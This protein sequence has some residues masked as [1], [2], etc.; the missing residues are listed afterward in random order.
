MTPATLATLLAIL[1]HYTA[2]SS[3]SRLAEIADLLCEQEA[4][5]TLEIVTPNEPLLCWTA[6][7]EPCSDSPSDYGTYGTM[8]WPSVQGAR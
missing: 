1:T 2:S 3:G 8:P 4:D 6:S 5:D 7:E